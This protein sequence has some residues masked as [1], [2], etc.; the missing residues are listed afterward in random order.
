MRIRFFFNTFIFVLIGSFIGIYVSFALYI[1]LFAAIISVAFLFINRPL[2]VCTLLM[3]FIMLIS[4]NLYGGQKQFYK[5]I[6]I[7]G[8]V[9]SVETDKKN[10][11]VILKNCNHK[12]IGRNKVYCYLTTDEEIR[13]GNKLTLTGNA[14]PIK[15]KKTNPGE[16][17]S[18]YLSDGIDYK[19]YPDEYEITDDSVSLAYYMKIFREQVRGIIFDNVENEDSAS[20]IYAMVTGDKSYIQNYIREIF[21]ACGTSHL[22]AVSGLHVSIFLSLII[23][24]LDKLKIRSIFSLLLLGGLVFLYSTFTG[25]S[26]SVLRASVMALAANL[27]SVTGERYDSV[28]SLGFAGTAI[29]LTEPFRVLDV[30]FQLS[31]LACLGIGWVLGHRVRIRPKILDAIKDAALISAGAT[32]FTLPL[33]IYYFG[34]IS[35]I[36][37][38]ANVLLV[39]VASFNLILAFIFILLALIWLPLGMLLH[40]SGHIMTVIIKITE[41]LAKAPTFTLRPIPALAVVAIVVMMI[42]FTRFVRFRFK[43]SVLGI[44]LIIVPFLW[45]NVAIY[46]DN[47]VKVHTPAFYNSACVH[48]EDNKHYV[49]GLSKKSDIKRQVEYIKR[50]VGKVDVLVLL[51]YEDMNLLKTAIDAGLQFEKLYG[52]SY[53]KANDI[54]RKNNMTIIA[55]LETENGYFDFSQQPLFICGDERVEINKMLKN[56]EY[57]RVDIRSH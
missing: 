26:S 9:E 19:F 30:G 16:F 53:M 43:I 1:A 21:S 33:L 50:N 46:N 15:E 18:S 3:A 27:S 20:V 22:L 12:V 42:F 48:I 11:T 34:I 10:A 51:D 29:L 36:S 49:I 37:I 8:I 35:I 32:I 7:E 56:K 25:F 2:A 17:Y 4:A 44:L 41:F 38:L 40:I 52:A 13:E 39:A 6:T 14:S 45:I 24:I 47:Y 28:N 5:N 55:K 23:L 57:S 31:F 54:A